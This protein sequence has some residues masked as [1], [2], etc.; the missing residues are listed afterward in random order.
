M[1]DE[2]GNAVLE[3]TFLG[4]LLMVPLTYVL[5]TV[6]AVQKAAYAVTAA[7]RE[8][9]RMFV[10]ASDED[11]GR[12]RADDAAR[13]ALRD[14]G[15]PATPVQIT[16]ETEPCLTPGASVRISVSTRVRLPFVPDV[17]G[18]A[19]ASVRVTGR[20]D[21]VVDRFRSAG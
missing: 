12:A 1:S 2:R 7:A 3:F 11:S 18:R 16:C 13:L 21:G 14:H 20:H 8:A 17:L 9:G 4:V 15:L 6:L 5:L 19:P 10:T